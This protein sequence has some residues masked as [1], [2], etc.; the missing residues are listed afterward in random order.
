MDDTFSAA[1]P[2]LEALRLIVS[3]AATAVDDQSAGDIVRELMVND[4]SR[5]Y[6]YAKATRCIYI[7][8]PEEDI[9]GN[10]NEIGRLELSLY[11]TRDGAVNWQDTLSNHLVEAGFIRGVGHPAVFMHVERDIWLMVHG[12]DYLSAAVKSSLDWLEEI[13]KKHYEIKTTRI[14]HRNSDQSEGQVLNRVI[15]AT[16]KGFELEADVRHAELIID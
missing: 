2:P 15:R 16:E 8:L 6:F 9:D 11:G 4:V 3:R 1:T 5:A 13:L 14:N 7:E 10:P 12:D